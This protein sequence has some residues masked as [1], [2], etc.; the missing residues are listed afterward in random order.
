M[1]EGQKYYQMP[2]D[3]A[4]EQE[5]PKMRTFCYKPT[6]VPFTCNMSMNIPDYA[7][8]P[9][10]YSSFFTGFTQIPFGVEAEIEVKVP[11]TGDTL[12]DFAEALKKLGM[13]IF[14]ANV[15]L[16]R[17]VWIVQRDAAKEALLAEPL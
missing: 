10:P 14:K 9:I 6:A 2:E 8:N 17:E 12:H 7:G 4:E 5:E 13:A 16:Q 11:D 1:T 15:E 3:V